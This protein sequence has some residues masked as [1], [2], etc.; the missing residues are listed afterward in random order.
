MF[1][2]FCARQCHALIVLAAL[3][4]VTTSSHVDISLLDYGAACDGSSN[5][6]AAFQN[7]FAAASAI[8]SV[9][10]TQVFVR[11]PSNRTCLTGPFNITSNHTTLFLELGSVINA[12][13]NPDLWPRGWPLPTYGPSRLISGFIGL[14]SLNASGIDGPGVIDANGQAWKDGRM[15]SSSNY[16]IR[17][18]VIIVHSSTNI[19]IRGVTILNAPCW[20]VHVVYSSFCRV[21]G[22]RINTPFMGTDGVDVD[23]SSN[24]VVANSFVSNG[25]DCVA[26]KS[27]WDCYGMKQKK[28]TTNVLVANM[29]CTAGSSIAVGSEMSGGISD[30][31][32]TDC[33]LFDLFG[34]AI[35][36]SWTK[37]RGG[38]I[39]NVTVRNIR[40]EGKASRYGNRIDKH[41][42]LLIQ[43][44]Y[45][46]N[47]PLSLDCWQ[48]N[49]SQN[50]ACGSNPQ[51]NPPWVEDI[52]FENISGWVPDGSP[53][54]EIVG[55]RPPAPVLSNITFR[56]ISLQAWPWQCSG[57]ST[58]ANLDVKNVTPQGLQA[59]CAGLVDISL[60]DHGALCD[61]ISNDTAAFQSAFAAAK[62]STRAMQFPAKVRVPKGRTCLTGPF[63]ITSNFTT[64]FLEPG[65]IV[66]AFDEP[67]LWPA[68]WSLPTYGP[69]RLISSFIG[70]YS[71]NGSGI[72]GQG[73]IDA[74]GRAWH[75]GRMSTGIKDTQPPHVILVHSSV[76]VL[77]S[78]VTILNAPSWNVHLV[79][80]KFCKVDG[81]R[82]E[83][84]F[85]GTDGV[86]V[87][88]SSHIVVT[89]S[90]V[91]NHDDCVSIKSGWDCFG[92]REHLPSHSIRI[93]NMTC[94]RGGSI[95]VGS[96]MSGGA[97]DI[98]I[99][100]CLMLNLSGPILSYRWTKHRGG[101]IRNV[102]ARNI[103]VEGKGMLPWGVVDTRP[104]LWV[105][106]NYGC[107][108]LL[109]RDCWDH[110]DNENPSCGE[111]PELYPPL[112]EDIIFDNVTGWVPSATPA[113][114]I[115][116][117]A[118]PAQIISRI[119][120]KD[121]NLQAGPWQCSGNSTVTDLVIEDV[122][123][124]GLRAACGL[125][126]QMLGK[127][128]ESASGAML[129]YV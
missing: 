100:D 83:T 68:A 103:R 113:G 97:S 79:Y 47:D 94:T 27:G 48:H 43:S 64:L 9:V 73:T 49:D 112:V 75:G 121:I 40:V 11:V 78:G 45:G 80:S 74:N 114:M 116:G 62:A 85:S 25:D 6:T 58:V 109:S 36:A 53:A 63:N 120:F 98:L 95:S 66:K 71:L 128:F 91:S 18:H 46:C 56:N 5:D 65:S 15:S 50:P 42:V 26:I 60:L 117:M 28:P 122:S 123:P 92:M 35:R 77:I 99:T 20:N 39:R 105:Q 89:N 21:D 30:I 13:D 111:K 67:A 31:L 14:Y 10:E 59:A 118:P 4:A 22:I 29:T 124:V 115:V 44:N 81:I 104:V 54:G 34:P 101:F 129:S 37:H 102:T 93:A 86:D 52:H 96:E 126:P 90:Y 19:L 127:S 51:I 82:V 1:A 12:S 88:S 87:D 16:S 8:V 7:A 76:N 108:D 33:F 110:H 32:I 55:L 107:N 119:S 2:M 23:S 3:L 125:S 41:P 57:P 61:G 24:I 17:P 106:S 72:D 84:P 70:L 38:Y 69:A